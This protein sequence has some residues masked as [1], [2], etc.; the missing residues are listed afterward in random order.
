MAIRSL[1][2][3]AR[4]VVEGF[5]SG[6]HR[7]PLHGFSV[8]F[9]EYRQ[10]TPG[11]D[12]RH[13]DWRVF[14][15][16]DRHFIKKFEDE[17]NLRCH[18]VLDRSRS[19]EFGSIGHTKA[20]YAATLAATLAYFLH[21]QGDAV[22]LLT[23]D[24]TVR[25]YLPARHRAGHLR[26]LMHALEA[27]A[28]GRAT[29]I[30]GPLARIA[31]IVRKRGLVLLV[32]DF[33]APVEALERPLTELVAAG[34]EVAAFQILDPAERDFSFRDASL[35][36]DIESGRSLH[37]DPAAAR[38]GYLERLAA[39][40][41]ALRALCAR[42]GVAWLPLVTDRPLELA[43]FDFL[44]GRARRGRAQRHGPKPEGR[45]AA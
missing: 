43:L 31:E 28:S 27:P 4:A 9:T 30:A 37:V 41:E 11:D 16:S 44:Q 2:L 39:H 24:E 42:R 17:T 6:L 15:R 19:M 1:E 35:F 45:A 33:L 38:A 8:E 26:H 40:Q 34:H 20:A 3:R 29:D 22:G 32:S 10:Y 23:F 12:P 21:L 5:W 13:L 25:G 36:E 14:A 18:V 7:S